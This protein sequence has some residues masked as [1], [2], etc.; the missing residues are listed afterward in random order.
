M[1]LEVGTAQAGLDGEAE[2]PADLGLTEGPGH[3][4]PGEELGRAFLVLEVEGDG[5]EGDEAFRSLVKQDAGIGGGF[6][7]GSGW[8]TAGG[9][10]Q[11]QEGRRQN[12]QGSPR[13]TERGHFQDQKA[14]VPSAISRG[15]SAPETS[16]TKT[17]D[18]VGVWPLRRS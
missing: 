10:K 5:A 1:G 13:T 15:D 16:M 14:R 3:L 4:H 6:R 12:A 8:G 11:G 2:P 18:P 17:R 9:E 7:R